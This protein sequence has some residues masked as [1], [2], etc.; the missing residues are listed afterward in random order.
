[1]LL[2]LLLLLLCLHACLHACTCCRA[3]WGCSLSGSSGG[4]GSRLYQEIDAGAA[5]ACSTNAELC[6]SNMKHSH[7]AVLVL[8]SSAMSVCLHVHTW[9]CCDM[10]PSE[11]ANL[12]GL[13]CKHNVFIDASA[14]DVARARHTLF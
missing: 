1:V 4:A 2:L 13:F 7:R 9:R 11:Q 12:H 14:A 8:G 6:C 5:W 3:L 10:Q